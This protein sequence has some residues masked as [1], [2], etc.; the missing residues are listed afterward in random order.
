MKRYVIKY[1]SL[2]IITVFLIVALP[3][4]RN[5]TRTPHELMLEFKKEYKVGG[6]LYYSSASEGE[7]G[8]VYDGFF[9]ALYGDGVGSVSDFALILLSQG[10]TVGEC[11][12][13][14]AYSEYDAVLISDMCYRRIS[15]LASLGISQNTEF[16]DGAFVLRRGEYVVMCALEDNEDAKRIW[17]KLIQS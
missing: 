17:K 14:L 2:L 13:F 9:E 15:F 3:S 8:Y 12:V 16:L 5:V 11:A 7:Q 4:C 10:D 1:I 6:V